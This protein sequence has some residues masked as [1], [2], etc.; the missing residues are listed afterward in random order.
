MVDSLSNA[1]NALLFIHSRVVTI[2]HPGRLTSLGPVSIKISPSNYFRNLAGPEETVITGSEFVV[3][4]AVLDAAG[5][6]APRRGDR[7]EDPE[8]GIAEITE[9]RPMHNLGA[10]IMGYRCRTS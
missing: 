10:S 1:F 5:F 9:V 6:P 3:S 2:E 8:T 7:I 4:K